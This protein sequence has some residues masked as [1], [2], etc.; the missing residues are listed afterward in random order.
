[1]AN[2]DPLQSEQLRALGS[3]SRLTSLEGYYLGGGTAVAFH[4]RH[5][6]SR[7]LDLFG[8]PGAADLERVRAEVMATL[9]D[10]EVVAF[11]DV[12]MHLKTSAGAIDIVA[13][14]YALLETANAG[15]AGFPVAGLLDLATMKLAAVSKRGVTRDFWD[16]YEILNHKDTTLNKA[17]EAYLNRFGKRESDLYHVI[18]SLTYFADAENETVL[19]SGMTVELWKRI[20]NFF[21]ANVPDLLRQIE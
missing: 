5:R 17:L 11:T 15:P 19:P 21:T 18:R 16:L 3:L 20:K 1:M 8:E 13:Y 2:V 4:L 6:T 10:A 9:D 7:D 14:P 12:A